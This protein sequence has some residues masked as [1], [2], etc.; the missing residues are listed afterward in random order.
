[1]MLIEETQVSSAALPVAAFKEHLRLGS[2]FA[3]DSLQ[4]GLLES[5]LQAA[6]SAVEART[7]K[8]LLERDFAWTLYG[9]N[10][11][12]AQGLPVAPVQAVSAVVLT[13]A[14][15]GEVTVATSAYQLVQDGHRPIVRAT[16]GALP[17]VPAEGSFTI[18]FTAGFGADWTSVPAD[19]RQA[20]FLLAAHFYEF[21]QDT[22]LSEGCMP[23]GVTSLLERYRVRRMT[24]GAGA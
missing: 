4:D 20:V 18:R 11:T 19:L 21:R 1:M 8:I 14:Q 7:G 22:R 16:S 12:E 6:L 9:P 24:L 23:F 5:F 3:E 17:Q 15:G 10:V 2:G 13:D